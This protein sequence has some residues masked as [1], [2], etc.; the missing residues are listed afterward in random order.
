M[1]TRPMKEHS[2]LMETLQ[3]IVENSD[4]TKRE[5]AQRAG[6]TPQQLS[7]I[8]HNQKGRQL[9][10]LERILKALGYEL[11]LRRVKE[12]TEKSD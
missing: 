3:I 11:A 10:Y 7:G 4:I 5:I 2:E 9:V 12:C 1:T 8:L 6:L